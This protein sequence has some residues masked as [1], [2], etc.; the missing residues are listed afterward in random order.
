VLVSPVTGGLLGY[1]IV[2]GGFVAPGAAAVQL[3][4]QALAA[5]LASIPEL[6]AI[7]GSAIY[8]QGLPQTHNL[9]AN[10][11]AL[12]Y[13]IPT[14]PRNHVLTGPDGTATARVQLDAWALADYGA[15]KTIVEVI[16][17]AID[18]PPGVWGN[19]TCTIVNVTHQDDIDAS[20]RPQAGSDKWLNHV[21]QEYSVMYRVNIPVTI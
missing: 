13:T 3:F 20:E 12:S 21:I 15:A 17:N 7:V 1:G 4:E 19:G 16:W 9:S 2:A 10:G 11:P 8:T 18:G 14:K 6:T 5:K